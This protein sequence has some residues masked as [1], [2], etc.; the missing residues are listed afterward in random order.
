MIS[1]MKTFLSGIPRSEPA[2]PNIEQHPASTLD[3]MERRIRDIEN[4]LV[5]VTAD[6]ERLGM[7]YQTLRDDLMR[8]QTSFCDR[9]KDSGIRAEPVRVPPA[10]EL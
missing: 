6:L 7:R 1:S 2:D 10:L 4:A 3:A 5:T 8:A 9:L